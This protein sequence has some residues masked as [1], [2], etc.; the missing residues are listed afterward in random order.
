MKK[1]LSQDQALAVSALTT[2]LAQPTKEVGSFFRLS[3]SAGMG[4]TFLLGHL[5]DSFRGRV[6]FTA[7]TNKAVRALKS[8]IAAPSYSPEFRTIFS[9]LGLTLQATGEIK[10]LTA[11]EDP[12][13]LSKYSLIIVDEASMISSLL[14]KHIQ[15]TSDSYKIRFLFIGDP[16]QLPPVGEPASPVWSIP[17]A[18]TSQFALSK[19]MRHDNTILDLATAAR[20]EIGKPAPCLNLKPFEF[21]L[22]KVP[23]AG[24]VIKYTPA[25]FLLSIREATGLGHF[26][27]PTGAKVIAWRNVTVDFWNKAIRDALWKEEA[28]NPWLPGDR[29]VFTS[30]ARDLMDEPMASTDDEGVVN[31]AVITSHP[32]FPEIKVY[33]I[34]ITL[35]DNKVASALVLHPS[36]N[37]IH[38][39]LL[40]RF[41]ADAKARPRLWKKFWEFKDSFHQLRHSY[42]LTAHR[43]QGSTYDRAF[44]CFSD[45]LL[46]RDRQEAFKCFYVAVTRPK[47]WLYLG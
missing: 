31:S 20:K 14:M 24:G 9:L 26:S 12:I 3:G 43:A 40:N 7:P 4:K 17:L 46:N 36:S 25:E 33:R 44:V 11:P 35:D 41:S 28:Q 32:N 47:T 2:W 37:L 10:V 42:A 34:S 16:A 19:V 13:D 8:A 15:E 23:K 21:T 1:A 27:T 29:V 22:G 38:L 30:P 18:D 39:E 6:V 5:P 45:I